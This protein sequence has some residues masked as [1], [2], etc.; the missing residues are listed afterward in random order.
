[1]SPL[2]YQCFVGTPPKQTSD[3]QRLVRSRLLGAYLSTRGERGQHLKLWLPAPR[4]GTGEAG[5]SP[6]RPAPCRRPLRLLAQT[7]S[8]GL[9]CPMALAVASAVL[10]VWI[11][12][13]DEGRETPN[14]SG[15]SKTEMY[16]V[17]SHRNGEAVAA[18]WLVDQTCGSPR[19]GFQ[20]V[21][22]HV[23][24]C[25]QAL[26]SHTHYFTSSS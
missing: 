2:H 23:V 6:P 14:K 7:G 8:R 26:S 19:P 1:M 24:F 17:L 11:K 4:P 18:C 20:A 22:H 10:S 9:P 16:F 3:A 5:F 13:S 25:A 15:F 12:P 21:R